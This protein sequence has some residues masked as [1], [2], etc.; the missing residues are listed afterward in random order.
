[1]AEWEYWEVE[2]AERRQ[3]MVGSSQLAVAVVG[4]L[5]SVAWA[6]TGRSA[7]LGRRYK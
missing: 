6:H 4:E 5:Q 7:A 2:E 3:W 1:M